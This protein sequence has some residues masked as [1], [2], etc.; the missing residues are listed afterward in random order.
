[1][2]SNSAYRR[3]VTRET[4]GLV[5]VLTLVTLTIGAA[6][7]MFREVAIVLGAIG[8]AWFIMWFYDPHKVGFKIT[9]AALAAI[10]AIILGWVPATDYLYVAVRIIASLALLAAAACLT[11]DRYE[12][13]RNFASFLF[14]RPHTSR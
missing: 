3:Y 4:I 12:D 7:W 10:V 8:V 5:V 6:I 11:I 1:M 2:T 13:I 14:P 9:F